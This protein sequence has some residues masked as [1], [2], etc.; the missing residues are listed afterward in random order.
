MPDSGVRVVQ[1]GTVDWLNQWVG[2]A[3]PGA[4]Q[5]IGPVETTHSVPDGLGKRCQ[6]LVEAGLIIAVWK[7]AAP[8][9]SDVRWEWRLSR[10]GRDLPA[11]W[12]LLVPP[13]VPG[14]AGAQVRPIP[15]SQSDAEKLY[16]ALLDA[17]L[18][19]RP[20]PTGEMMRAILQCGGDATVDAALNV[21]VRDG[22]C[23][24]ARAGRHRVFRF[25]DLDVA[26][27][28]PGKRVAA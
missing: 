7:A 1:A 26:T 22:R 23:E 25:P 14:S 5:M 9:G 16:Q 27:A 4:R 15:K 20:A 17:A 3:R 11:C 6:A 13:R 12:P 8:V 19:D 2:H 24:M 28:V 18:A 21:L 10:T